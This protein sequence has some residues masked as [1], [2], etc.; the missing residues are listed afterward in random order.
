MLLLS[1]LKK[2]LCVCA[3]CCTYRN[4]VTSDALAIVIYLRVELG[5]SCAETGGRGG[6]SC[7]TKLL[8][9]IQE[10]YPHCLLLGP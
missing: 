6:E 4:G 10:T 5:S 3:T 8:R 7:P 9:S 2:A 1:P